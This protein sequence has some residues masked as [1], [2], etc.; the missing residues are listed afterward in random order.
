MTPLDIRL[1]RFFSLMNS[2]GYTNRAHILKAAIGWTKYVRLNHRHMRRRLESK[3]YPL[4]TAAYA[5][6]PTIQHP[7]FHITQPSLD[8][9]RK[10]LLPNLSDDRMLVYCLRQYESD[11]LWAAG[12]G[13]FVHTKRKTE[14]V[15]PYPHKLGA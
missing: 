6:K 11:F 2:H 9:L 4:V 1:V 12:G 10:F 7:I 13:H 15:F 5:A 14:I 8:D 3:K